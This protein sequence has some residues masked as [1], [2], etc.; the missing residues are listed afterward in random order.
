MKRTI[1]IALVLMCLCVSAYA[2]GDGNFE[3]AE[4]DT[5]QAF[6]LEPEVPDV[7]DMLDVIAAAAVCAAEIEDKDV[8]LLARLI[9][10]E[11]RGVKNRMEQAA[12]A[13][14]V[15]N[16]VDSPW[17]PDTISAVVTQRYQF[18]NVSGVPVEDD[19]RE[20]AMNVLFRWN[21][22]KAGF[23]NVGR[24][25]PKDY[26]YF[27]G[28]GKNNFFR[29]RHNAHVYWDWSNENPYATEQ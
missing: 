13:W 27:W 24:V 21:M 8:D 9:Y 1:S 3:E 5:Q 7:P 10:S 25:L 22:E 11:A 26:L 17:Y 6:V 4:M 14:C 18:A 28:N 15:L 23:S 20:L 12:V 19:L 16:R 29:Q 2:A